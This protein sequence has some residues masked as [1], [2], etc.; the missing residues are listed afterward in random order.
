M[1]EKKSDFIDFLS[2]NDPLGLLKKHP[3]AKQRSKRTVLLQNFE[4]IVNFFEEHEREP[5]K[6][7]S[8][9]YEFQLFCRLEAIRNNSK[10][11]KELK[12]FDMYGLLEG[13]SIS[14]ITL[15]DIL[16]D[17]PLN[18]LSGDYDS[19]IFEMSHV[20]KSDRIQP[21]YISR[22]KF[23]QN[24]DTYRPM[25]ESLHKDLEEGKRKLAV[26]HSQ[27]LV[28]DKFYVLGGVIVYLK[29]VDGG[30]N[31]YRFK[32]GDRQR[33]D[34][35][36]CCIF[37][38]GTTSDMLYRSLD[39]ALQKEGYT[40]TDFYE[41]QLVAER[42]E[43]NDQARGFVYVLKSKHAKL[44][45]VPDVYKIGS[46]TTSVTDRIKNAINEPTYLYA[47]VEVVQVYR[48]Y[49]IKPR[50]LED[51][52]HTFFD[53]VRLNINIPDDRGVV[54]SP[55]EWFCVNINV[56]GEAVDKII[57]R[58]IAGYVYDP[59]SRSIIAKSASLE[60]K[61]GDAELYEKIINEINLIGKSMEQKPSL[62]Q[63]KDEEALRDVFIAMLERRFQ[64]VTATAETFNHI[65]KTD[66][67]LKDATD[68]SNLFIG[69]C[70]IW[71]GKKHFMESINQ[72]FDRYLTWRDTNAAL[73]VFVQGTDLTTVMSVI[74]DS[75]TQ[76]QYYKRTCGKHNETSLSYIFGLPQDGHRDV[77]LEVMVFNFDKV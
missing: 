34:G 2:Q 35:R 21:E 23:C 6:S 59:S 7:A 57:H 11:V 31:L 37:D 61:L 25:F 67:L 16:G 33:F 12:E 3:K 14:N 65:G 75:V 10:M 30:S 18:L 41:E 62:Y 71:R 48:C 53:Q 36:T 45:N 77:K 60:P 20:Q 4:E 38:N 70:K 24:F 54:I 26:Y 68:S 9:I 64:S 15:E 43:E 27:D 39:K 74:E 1:V 19:S 50:E 49:N 22:R 8:D 55:R 69:E 51:R 73:M 28:P 32:S 56:I 44:R 17:D 40:I 13:V 46:T 47:G 66:I 58:T 52:L 72:L 76:H 63:G 5:K 42:I 29:S